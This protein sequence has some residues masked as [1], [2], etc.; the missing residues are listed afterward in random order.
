MVFKDARFNGWSI[1]EIFAI[2]PHLV[3]NARRDNFEKNPA[4]FSLHEQLMTI[5]A[6]ITKEIRSASL[7]RNTELAEALKHSERIISDAKKEVINGIT[8]SQKG[9]IVQKVDAARKELTAVSPQ[10]DSEEYYQSVAFEELDILI[11]KIKGATEYKSI[12]ISNTLSKAEKKT[13]EQVFDVITKTAD[14]K[15]AEELISK[16]LESFETHPR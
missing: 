16:I 10:M 8:P 14:S 7:K 11:G 9:V 3:P 13:L 12:N 6:G 15:T 5:A 1:G 4:Y 2:D